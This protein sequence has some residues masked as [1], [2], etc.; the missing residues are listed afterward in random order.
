MTEHLRDAGHRDR[1]S[2]RRHDRSSAR[3][4]PLPDSEPSITAVLRTRAAEHPDRPLAAQRDRHDRWAALTYGE[5][6]QRS[7][8]LARAFTELGLGPE[9][10]VM[11]LSGNSLEHLLVSLGA[12][13]AGVPV[14]PISVAYSLM[15]ADHARIRAIAELTE[16]GLVFAD[17]AGPF[18][19]ALDAL[20]AQVPTAL[21][22]TGDRAGSLRLNQAAAR[23]GSPLDGDPGPDTIAKLLFT[24]G[25]TGIP[26]G[27]I[28]TH[29]M[30]CSNQAML[31]TAGRS[32][33]RSRRCSSTGSRGATRSAATT[34]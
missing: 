5:A 7:D 13:A 24:S 1:A 19:P 20:A 34:T 6:K 30:L 4:T 27:V 17:D 3:G 26:K 14:M 9:R 2:R 28:N 12:Y 23:D 33:P 18:G 10:P 8:A 31:G 11:I 25:S 22:G 15:S 16:P 21:V 29:R 32:S